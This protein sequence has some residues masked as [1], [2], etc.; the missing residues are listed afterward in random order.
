MPASAA[1]PSG[2][3][4]SRAPRIGEAP[5]VAP[6]HLDVGQQMMAEGHRLRRLQVRESRHHRVGMRLGLVDE[7]ELQAG[8][9]RSI[10]A[11]IASRT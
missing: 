3:S 5:A 6:E 10:R 11:S 8:E 2:H 1:A 7:R 4:L 9:R